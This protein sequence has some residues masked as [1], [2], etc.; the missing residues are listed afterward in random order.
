MVFFPGICVALLALLTLIEAG[1]QKWKAIKTS[2]DPAMQ[3]DEVYSLLERIKVGLSTEFDVHIDPKYASKIN[4]DKVT[5]AKEDEVTASGKVKVI[6]NSG[7]AATCGIH[8]YLK[9][10]CGCHF[11]WDT[12]RLNNGEYVKTTLIVV[13]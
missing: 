4:T 13:V 12:I 1:S 3:R 5:V 6:A 7:V 2:L 9:Y 11:S 10:N 8:H